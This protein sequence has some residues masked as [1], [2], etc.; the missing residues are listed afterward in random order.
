MKV[1]STQLALLA[2]C[3]A[4]TQI[5]V[6]L[7]QTAANKAR[8][9]QVPS[10]SSSMSST[11][12]AYKQWEERQKIGKALTNNAWL[13]ESWTGNNAPYAAIR[14]QIDRAFDI[15]SPKAL[16]TRYAQAAKARPDDPLALF[17]WGYAVHK[18]I[19]SSQ[20]PPKDVETTLLAAEVAL[21]E[22]PFPNTYDAARLRFMLILQG[23]FGDAYGNLIG[24]A[25]RL[26]QTNPDD[27]PVK[28]G[29]IGFLSHSR[30]PSAQKEGYSLIQTVIKQDPN[31]PQ[32]YDLLGGWHY[33]QYLMYHKP[34]N[35]QS[36]MDNYQKAMNLYP[37]TASRRSALPQIMDFLTRRYHQ[38]SGA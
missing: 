37:M 1:T 34:A 24:T 29:L 5:P 12:L 20:F 8:V 16:V 7:G 10:T 21:G 32:G 4:A 19:T 25:R 6:A 31:Q 17:A 13:H 9:S 26:L 36:S 33:V 15:T 30:D 38:I 35:Y 23:P 27:F 28:M 18:A 3:L 11:Q 2:L 14:A 22:A